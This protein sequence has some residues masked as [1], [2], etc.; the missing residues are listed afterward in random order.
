MMQNDP[1]FADDAIAIFALDFA[2]F[3]AMKSSIRR[4]I[5]FADR[6]IERTVDGRS[7]FSTH[8]VTT[9]LTPAYHSRDPRFA[10][11]SPF[12]LTSA[13]TRLKKTT[14]SAH[15]RFCSGLYSPSR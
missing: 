13:T 7:F 12:I 1:I 9:V 10:T 15:C 11:C 6:P 14:I 5:L 8:V 3:K 2:S 4:Q